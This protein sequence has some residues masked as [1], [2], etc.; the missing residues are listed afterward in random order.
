MIHVSTQRD[1]P[2]NAG[3]TQRSSIATL[4]ATKFDFSFDGWEL[5]CDERQPDVT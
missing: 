3:V 5:I 1:T 4:P 2:L